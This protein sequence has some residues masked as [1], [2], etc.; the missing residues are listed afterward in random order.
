MTWSGY[1]EKVFLLNDQYY[2][3]SNSR[4]LERLGLIIKSL[5]YLLLL[6][7]KICFWIFGIV[8]WECFINYTNYNQFDQIFKFLC[9]FYTEKSSFRLNFGM[10]SSFH[11]SELNHGFFNL[12]DPIR[13]HLIVVPLILWPCLC[14][15]KELP[16]ILSRVW[17]PNITIWILLKRFGFN[18]WEMSHI[19]AKENWCVFNLNQYFKPNLTYLISKNFPFSFSEK[20]T[21]I[22]TIFL[23]VLTFTK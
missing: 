5:E 20:T 15:K 22:C 17:N 21:E 11:D 4:S 16:M 18:S 14:T 6:I 9:H 13:N 12:F 10:I 7:S 3:F 19:F 8:S 23:R 1:R 2:L